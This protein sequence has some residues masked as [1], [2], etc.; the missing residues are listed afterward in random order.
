MMVG[1]EGLLSRKNVCLFL[2]VN[3][4]TLPESAL[5]LIVAK[6]VDDASKRA[7]KA[8]CRKFRGLV[9]KRHMTTV[10]IDFFRENEALRPSSDWIGWKF[11]HALHIFASDSLK[12]IFSPLPYSMQRFDAIRVFHVD[13]DLLKYGM[14]QCAFPPA[15]STLFLNKNQTTDARVETFGLWERYEDTE[16]YT[17]LHEWDTLFESISKQCP[18]LESISISAY[19]YAQLLGS[20]AASR[21]VRQRL[22]NFSFE[23]YSEAEHPYQHILKCFLGH[24]YPLLENLHF[25]EAVMNRC[26]F[27]FDETLAFQAPVLKTFAMKDDDPNPIAGLPLPS[28]RWALMQHVLMR[29][30]MVVTLKI[31]NS[32]IRE[33][34]IWVFEKLLSL[35]PRVETLILAHAFEYQDSWEYYIGHDTTTGSALVFW[36]RVCEDIQIWI[37]RT[38]PCPHGLRWLKLV[39]S[40][41]KSHETDALLSSVFHILKPRL[42]PNLQGVDYF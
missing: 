23:S 4:D 15:I 14:V 7:F 16:G 34:I 11:A 20:I 12:T 35:V 31:E 39:E 24:T 37:E 21:F 9:L 10:R 27:R 32:E 26:A 38:R 3:M 33:Y 28:Q 17:T 30:P 13:V 36:R 6:L 5:E 8:T 18:R 41:C 1:F 25:E 22:K 42:F 19:E 29:S 40:K 2:C